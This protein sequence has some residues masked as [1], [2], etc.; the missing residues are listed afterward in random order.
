MTRR[1]LSDAVLVALALGL[2]ATQVQAQQAPRA[3]R[4]AGPDRSAPDRRA[5]PPVIGCP[6]LANYRMLMRDGAAAAAAHLA[7]P[8]ADH[9]GC[10][11]LAR[12]EV[13]GIVDKVTLGG[14]SYDCAG[15]RGTTACH[16]IAPGTIPEAPAPA[17]R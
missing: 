10:A 8:K 14:Q 15:V 3:P 1:P 17:K 11:A 13:T 12:T 16:W 6:S 2:G 7:D 5:G 4:A 9:L